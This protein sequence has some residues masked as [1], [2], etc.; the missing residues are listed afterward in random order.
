MKCV[1]RIGTVLGILFLLG[2]AIGVAE[3]ATAD[4]P[5]KP[6]TLTFGN[7]A[8]VIADV[9]LRTLTDTAAKSLGRPIIIVNKPGA[10]TALALAQ[11]KNDK[12]DGYSLGYITGSSVLNPHVQKVAYDINN[13]FTP[14]IKY[15]QYMMGLVVR[16]DSPWKTMEEFIVYAKANPGKIK[17]AHTGTGT[18]NHMAM[19]SLGREAGAKWVPISYRGGNE[20]LPALLGGHVDAASTG[21]DWAPYVASGELRLIATFGSS[22]YKSYPNV[23]TFVD[24]GYK[25]WVG[26]FASIVGPKGIPGPVVEKL[27]GALREAMNNPEFIRVAKNAQIEVAHSDPAQ[28]AKDIKALDEQFALYVKELGLK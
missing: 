5:T 25:T 21:A 18:V 15:G 6:I 26:S 14:I 24:L 11:T 17:Y 3:S 16:A 28:L 10:A 23:P 1:K 4:F 2:G 9:L 13:D 27:H 19:E 12:P 8:G 20:A 7:A 22:R